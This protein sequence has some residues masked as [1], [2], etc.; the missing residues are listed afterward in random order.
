MWSL[1]LAEG[2]HYCGLDHTWR[3]REKFEQSEA[4]WSL[5]LGLCVLLNSSICHF[6]L[7]RLLDAEDG[8]MEEQKA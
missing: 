6:L 5:G 4:S 7:P 1:M 3:G 8:A 2:A